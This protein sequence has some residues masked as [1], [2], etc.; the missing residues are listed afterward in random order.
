MVNFS[1]FT[2]NLIF[3]NNVVQRENT[4]GMIDYNYAFIMMLILVW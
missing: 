4:F 2:F 1:S 3:I